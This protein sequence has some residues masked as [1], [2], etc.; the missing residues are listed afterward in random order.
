MEEGGI[1][2]HWVPLKPFRSL[3]DALRWTNPRNWGLFARA[4]LT[5]LPMSVAGNVE[6]VIQLAPYLWRLSHLPTELK[7]YEA[8]VRCAIDVL[9]YT[10]GMLTTIA[11]TLVE[12]YG[13]MEWHRTYLAERQRSKSLIVARARKGRIN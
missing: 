12:A 9:G 3:I 2:E 8:Q 5:E 13:F 11:A 4:F 10:E 7:R 1:D 6:L